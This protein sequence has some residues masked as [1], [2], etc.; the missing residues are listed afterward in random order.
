[1]DPTVGIV[2]S[3]E[4]DDVVLN[5]LMEYQLTV[6]ENPEDDLRIF[7]EII[8]ANQVRSYNG[9]DIKT[10]KKIHDIAYK[11]EKGKKSLVIHKIKLI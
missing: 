7:E 1:M 6:Q 5:N 9:L 11:D 10:S 8:F 2:S 3:H 4:I